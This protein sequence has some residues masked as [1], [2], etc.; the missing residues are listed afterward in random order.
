MALPFGIK[1]IIDINDLLKMGNDFFSVVGKKA[2]KWIQNDSRNGILQEPLK[3]TYRSAEYMRRKAS[4]F[5]RKDGKGKIAGFSGQMSS[6]RTDYVDMRLTGKLMRGL[7]LIGTNPKYAL[8]A[9]RN[10]DAKKLEGNAVLG[11]NI[12]TVNEKNHMKFARLA[13]RKL[14]KNIAQAAKDDLTIIL[15]M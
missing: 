15:R 4:R 2:V 8:I 14:E 5:N 3:D 9:Y 11:R 7:R 10:E 1:K 6:T 12:V 13:M